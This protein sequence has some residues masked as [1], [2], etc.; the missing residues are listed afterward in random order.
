MEF[1]IKISFFLLFFFSSVFASA[2]KDSSKIKEVDNFVTKEGEFFSSD[3]DSTAYYGLKAFHEAESI[4]YTDGIVNSLY[5]LIWTFAQKGKID[6]SKK[7]FDIAEKIA[8]RY[9]KIK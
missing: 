1:F 2:Q 8:I 7:Y 4:N 6:S 3:I 5:G 9:N